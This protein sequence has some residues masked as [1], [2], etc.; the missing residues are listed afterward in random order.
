MRYFLIFILGLI[1]FLSP[2]QDST[3]VCIKPSTARYYLEVEDEMY[4]LREK[5][6]LNTQLIINLTEQVLIKDQIIVTYKA[7]SAS[8]ESRYVTLLE[9]STLKQ[10]EIERLEKSVRKERTLKFLAVL[11]IIIAAIL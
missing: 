7:D 5:D 11:G 10:Q 2:A 3:T 1:P 6:S 9:S 4:V 8:Y